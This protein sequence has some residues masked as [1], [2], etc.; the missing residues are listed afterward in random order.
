MKFALSVPL[1]PSGLRLLSVGVAR[2]VA[3]LGA[4]LFSASG[5]YS[6]RTPRN[7]RLAHASRADSPNAPGGGDAIRREIDEFN[8]R[9]EG[10][11]ITVVNALPPLATQLI[12]RNP[13]F[14]AVNWSWVSSQ[15]VTIAAL[16]RFAKQ[17][18]VHVN[19]RFV[20]WDEAFQGLGDPS[21]GSKGQPPD[22]AQ[23]GGRMVGL[24]RVRGVAGLAAGRCRSLALGPR[25]ACGRA[26]LRTTRVA[27]FLWGP[28]GHRSVG[29]EHLVSRCEGL[30]IR[31]GQVSN[32][33]LALF[34]LTNT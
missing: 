33:S 13:Q 27:I 22:V 31:A 26:S 30:Q 10:K 6:R 20:T 12:I 23:I 4:V 18:A 34:K 1:P 32:P 8:R 15:L 14:S 29:P 28:A 16:E 17:S 5:C 9:L 3:L 24:F 25:S 7:N 2:A 11:Q 19:V 21:A